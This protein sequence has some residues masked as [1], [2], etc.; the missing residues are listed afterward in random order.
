LDRV[1]A[2]YVLYSTSQGNDLVVVASQQ[3]RLVPTAQFLFD[4]PKLRAL[5]G[6][7]KLRAAGDLSLL[8]VGSRDWLRPYFESVPIPANSDFFP[9]LDLNASRSRFL[10]SQAT[11]LT[12]MT[13]AGLPLI[14]RLDPY[15]GRDRYALSLPLSSEPRLRDAQL[16]HAALAALRDEDITGYFPPKPM[17]KPEFETSSRVAI[18]LNGENACNSPTAAQAWLNATLDILG[19]ISVFI[20]GHHSHPWHTG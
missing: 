11:A 14:H 19:R 13:Q 7:A 5:M 20:T 8:R 9:I 12:R 1:F 16:A 15:R 10:R 4:A 17:T 3:H 2:D 6:N 18:I